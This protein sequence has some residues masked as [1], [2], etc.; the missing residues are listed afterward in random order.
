MK[1][2]VITAGHSNTDSGAVGYLDGKQ[3]TER[4]LMVDL[5]NAVV[6]YLKQSGKYKVLTDG[7]GKDNQ[8]LNTAI[9]LVKQKGVVFS[10]EL[11]MNAASAKSANGVETI[12]LPKDKTI[13]QN[14]S[15]AVANVLGSKLRGDS[16]WIDQSKSA[17]GKLGFVSAGGVIAEI[18]FISN[19]EK[20]KTY[21]DKYWLVAKAIATEIEKHIN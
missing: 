6:V 19:P 12:S 5:R 20:L 4:D 9:S 8:N 10:L 16:G 1:T 21:L 7:V 18:E 2:I 15:K 14:I 3:Y 17:R 13:S 11:H